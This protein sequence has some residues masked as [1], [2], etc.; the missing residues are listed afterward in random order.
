MKISEKI[1][2]EKLLQNIDTGF[3]PKDLIVSANVK[4]RDGQELLLTPD[5]YE[6]ILLQEAENFR[7]DPY[8]EP[9]IIEMRMMLDL[10]KINAL[11]KYYAKELD[12][13]FK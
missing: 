10:E 5:E 11:L 2:L 9:D 7:D 8:S 12:T 4:T 1:K 6:D 3:I 13:V